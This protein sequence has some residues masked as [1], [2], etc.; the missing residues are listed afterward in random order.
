MK[1]LIL[2][3]LHMDYGKNGYLTMKK[4]AVIKDLGANFDCILLCGDN[5][6]F[7]GEFFNHKRLFRFLRNRFSCPLGFI[8][9]N[10]ELWSGRFISPE[11]LLYK[12]FK[13]IALEEGLVYLEDQNLTINN[14]TIAGTYAHYDYSLGRISHGITKENFIIGVAKINGVDYQWIDKNFIYWEKPDEDICSDLTSGFENRI[15]NVERKLITISHTVPNQDLIGHENSLKQDFYGAFSGTIKLEEII[16]KFPIDYHFCGHTH[17]R[18]QAPIGGA[19]AMNVGMDYDRWS[20][21]ILNTEN[22][23]IE[24]FFKQLD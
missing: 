10:H 24:R 7:D 20:H 15:K 21:L 14:W 6:E 19:L 18:T 4:E 2:S 11:M 23:S 17:A 13:D 9:G 3:D 5:A 12:H 22:R 16:K 8:I 1:V